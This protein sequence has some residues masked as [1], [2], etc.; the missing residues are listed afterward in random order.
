MMLQSQ[1]LAYW[2]NGAFFINGKQIETVFPNG[3]SH[4]WLSDDGA[5]WAVLAKDKIV[6]NGKE[7]PTFSYIVNIEVCFE[8]DS[9]AFIT[10]TKDGKKAVVVNGVQG[11]G[12]EIVTPPQ[13]IADGAQVVYLATDRTK[14]Y[15]VVVS[16][17]SKQR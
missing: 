10:K 8:S 16:T 6:Y 11:P 1:H 9:Y 14:V 3:I 7:G 2:A 15:R 5:D 12:Y 13:F 17:D 4:I